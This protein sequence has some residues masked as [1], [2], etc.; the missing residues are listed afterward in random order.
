VVSSCIHAD[1]ET[2]DEKRDDGWQNRRIGR[3]TQDDSKRTSEDVL[4]N[5]ELV[6]KF[7][8]SIFAVACEHQQETAE[9]LYFRIFSGEL[10]TV[11]RK[12][13]VG[14]GTLNIRTWT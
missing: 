12:T 11:F 7:E 6:V 13:S 4:L 1:S 14:L 3:N 2:V 9:K 8:L 5:S 10:M